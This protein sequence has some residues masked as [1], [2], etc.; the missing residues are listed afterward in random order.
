[1][2][3][4]RDFI[5]TIVDFS[6]LNIRSEKMAF[7]VAFLLFVSSLGIVTSHVILV[8]MF[9]ILWITPKKITKNTIE[10]KLLIV[11]AI[12]SFINEILHIILTGDMGS[13]ILELIP[14]SCL[15]Y[16]T[17]WAAEVADR[18]V[19]KWLIALTIFEVFV[20]V[21]QRCVGINSF[22]PDSVVEVGEYGEGALLYNFKVNGLGV[23]STSIAYKC[24][25]SL[26]LYERFPECRF[27]K[28]HWLIMLCIL[29][30]ILS[31]NRTI[32]IGLFSYFG[33]LCL[34]KGNRR[35]L[36]L[37][38]L[39]CVGVVLYV[40]DVIEELFYQVTR[41]GD[42][43]SVNAM[44][45]R[46]DIFPMYWNFFTNNILM[47]NGSFKLFFQDGDFTLHAHNA[48]LQTLA[49]NG[50]IISF[51]Y[52]IFLFSIVNRKNICYA[53]PFFVCCCF[54]TFILWGT[55]LNDFVFYAILLN[56]NFKIRENGFV[57][58]D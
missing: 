8:S 32:M 29:G 9:L 33:L 1:M 22:F 5:F 36:F 12:S 31:F 26:M 52:I 2:R 49:T 19:F 58:S 20:G 18:K 24:F 10:F 13:G 34:K 51:M 41:G 38:L 25:L 15:I 17:V 45:G 14:Y 47:G 39:A 42:L 28:R 46:E 37:L 4:I 50:L 23:N 21:W 43:T 44:S 40:P 35:Y 53:I 16:F 6:K 30:T 48:F 54:Q 7:F 27:I 57:Y 11:I 56:N 55:S 3:R